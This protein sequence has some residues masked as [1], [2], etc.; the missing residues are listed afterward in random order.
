MRLAAVVLT[1]IVVLLL[2]DRFTGGGG[3]MAGLLAGLLSAFGAV[4]WAQSRAWEAAERERDSRLYALI[5]PDALMPRL[6][7]LQVF[8]RPRPGAARP[9]ELEPSPF[10][11]E[12]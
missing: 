12:I 5:R 4:E 1:G 3:V 10:D 7:E 9:G 8:E 6:G 11:L 2:F